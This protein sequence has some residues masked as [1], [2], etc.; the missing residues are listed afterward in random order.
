MLIGTVL[1]KIELSGLMENTLIIVTGDHGQEFNDNK[2]NFW[3]HNGNFTKAQIGVPLV[4]FV[5]KFKP[6]KYTYKTTHYDISPTIM[7]LVL[8]CQNKSSDYS[9][10]INL[11]D[12]TDRRS[13]VV[14]S[15]EN[16]GIISKNKIITVFP[17]GSYSITDQHLNELDQ[18][19]FDQ[20]S[21]FETITQINRFYKTQG[22]SKG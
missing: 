1:R 14:G 20:K 3:G 18:V 22:K 5:P 13:F 21:I 6:A 4:L 2:K 16:F 12:S 9:C 7:Q 19:Q 15:R 10:G 17:G 11:F 8:G